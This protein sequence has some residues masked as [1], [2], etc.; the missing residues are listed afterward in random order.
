MPV[1]H[2]DDSAESQTLPE[3]HIR[4]EG[5]NAAFPQPAAPRTGNAAHYR[6]GRRFC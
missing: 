2:L 3:L 4:I 6:N 5:V 1:L